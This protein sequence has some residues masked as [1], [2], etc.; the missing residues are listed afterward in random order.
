MVYTSSVSVMSIYT[1]KQWE[2]C[3]E[4]QPWCSFIHSVPSC[5][6]SLDKQRQ[7]TWFGLG[8]WQ[9]KS[10]ARQRQV[11]ARF[12]KY[13]NVWRELWDWFLRRVRLSNINNDQR[14]KASA[15]QDKL[16]TSLR[17]AWGKLETSLRPERRQAWDKRRDRLEIKE[18]TRK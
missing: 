3:E 5:Y 1:R 6:N 7:G 9:E 4:Q 17:Q 12:K 16:E 11:K 8:L 2:R 14:T 15:R 10:I 18:E 13:A